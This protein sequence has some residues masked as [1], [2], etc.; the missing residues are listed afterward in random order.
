MIDDTHPYVQG[1][2]K[3]FF[4]TGP[5]WATDSFEWL[6]VNTVKDALR[7]QALMGE[8]SNLCHL[9]DELISRRL[10]KTKG[11]EA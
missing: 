11:E 2:V 4:S 1:M 6:L 3:A 9:A 8:Q 10:T 5:I 7:F